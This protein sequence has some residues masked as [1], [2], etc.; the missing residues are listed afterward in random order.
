MTCSPDQWVTLFTVQLFD[1]G[2]H[3]I[4]MEIMFELIYSK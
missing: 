1:E 3:N 4:W 2:E